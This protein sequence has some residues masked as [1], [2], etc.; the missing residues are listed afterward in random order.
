MPSSFP[1]ALDAFT[2]P[3][4]GDPMNSPSHSDQHADA[5]DAIEAMQTKIGID[6]SADTDSLD[7]K[8]NNLSVDLSAV[9]EDILPDTD[10]TRDVGS[11]THR[12]AE[13]RGVKGFLG[14]GFGEVDT[15]GPG[16]SGVNEDINSLVIGE[17]VADSFLNAG[18]DSFALGKVDTLGG[19]IGTYTYDY[20]YILPGPPYTEYPNVTKPYGS[21]AHGFVKGGIGSIIA[22]G[23]GSFAG[24]YV[25]NQGTIF[26]SYSGGMAF[27]LS[28]SDGSAT[29]SITAGG[30]SLA[31]GF[32]YTGGIINAQDYSI[33]FGSARGVDGV[34]NSFLQSD[35]GSI[36]I[37]YASY[38]GQIRADAQ[39]AVA[40]G[41]AYQA[42]SAIKSY[43]DGGVAMGYAYQGGQIHAYA[44]G[45]FALGAAYQGGQI[46]AYA[47]GSFA[48][49]MAYDTGSKIVTN[50]DGAFAMGAAK[51]GGE[52]RADGGKG[53]FAIGYAYG[54]AALV[55]TDA[56]GAFSLGYATAGFS[57]LATAGGAFAVGKAA[58][59]NIEANAINSFQFGMGVNALADTLQVG[60]QLRFKG[61]TGAQASPANGDFWVANNYVYIRSNGVTCKVV[62]ATL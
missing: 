50:Y 24:G 36:A 54:A 62:N 30:G 7:Y 47:D 16:D 22:Q 58:T 45:A 12:W 44:E 9:D 31:G 11:P 42:G 56:P 46:H 1:T 4:A 41:Y 23:Y 61:T 19:K 6:G 17:A 3:A 21:I 43:S 57:V 14:T 32:A 53:S 10:N 60:T 35:G 2:N 38:G 33:A 29:A 5:N 40:M 8:I 34:N 26:A 37:G 39:G 13:F 59:A 25:I 49:G 27:G 20:T 55:K 28:Q 48:M 15:S 51:D 18:R 52:I